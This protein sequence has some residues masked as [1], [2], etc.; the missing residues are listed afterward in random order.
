MK[1]NGF[2]LCQASLKRCIDSGVTHIRA[3]QRMNA[4]ETISNR[5]AV[6]NLKFE[7]I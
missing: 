4:D 1:K 6:Q 2:F 7:K 5:I 3:T